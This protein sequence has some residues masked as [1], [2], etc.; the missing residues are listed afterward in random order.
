MPFLGGGA[1]ATKSSAVDALQ[2]GECPSNKLMNVSP[3]IATQA[4]RIYA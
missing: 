4:Q 2:G 3:Q 1:A